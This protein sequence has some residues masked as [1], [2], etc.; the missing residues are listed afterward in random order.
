MAGHNPVHDSGNPSAVKQFARGACDVQLDSHSVAMPMRCA[1]CLAPRQVTLATSLSRRRSRLSFQIPYCH[2]C[3]QRAV[4]ARRRSTAV[5]WVS[6]GLALA[7]AAAGF[8][9]PQRSVI[10]LVAAP[11]AV[12]IAFGLV[13]MIALRPRRPALPATAAGDAV[14]LVSFR[15][16]H[17]VFSCTNP[18]WATE[19]AAANEAPLRPKRRR[20]WFGLRTVVIAALVTPA[21]AAT[22][23]M[24]AHPSVRIDNAGDT[25]LQI[26]VDGVA[27]KL[28]APH[29]D[30][31]LW[32]WVAYGKHTFG[33]SRVGADRPE[34]TTEVDVTMRG[35]HLYNPGKTAC[36]RLVVN[37][38][39]DASTSDEPHGPVPVSEYYTFHD[40]YTWFANNPDHVQVSSDS[41]G[42]TKTALQRMDDCPG[43]PSRFRQP[44]PGLRGFR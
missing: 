41:S 37:R 26:W 25:T 4:A 33:Y 22:V 9:V 28:A 1:S 8:L 32:M 18:V 16:S 31:P 21:A 15:G 17:S 6:L 38:Y 39:G 7:G 23:Y 11:T 27:T 10:E 29:D 35:D 19:L 30:R 44:P 12:S 36:Y 5:A 40:I 42:T 34:H 14:T 24:L 20:A 2:S 3:A 13:A 43:A